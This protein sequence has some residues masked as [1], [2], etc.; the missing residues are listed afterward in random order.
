MF[1]KVLIANRGEIACRV[2][3]TLDRLGLVDEP[4]RAEPDSLNAAVVAAGPGIDDHG[5]VDT[6]MLHASEHFETIYPWHLEV[7]HHAVDRLPRQHVERG[8][9][10]GYVGTTGWSTGCHLHFTVLL[11]GSP[12]NPIATF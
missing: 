5:R 7:E 8:Q 3:D 2:L 4:V 6:T 10:I 12:V 11:N 1:R 9:I